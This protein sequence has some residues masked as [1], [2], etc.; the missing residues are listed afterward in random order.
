[1]REGR[2]EGGRGSEHYAIAARPK[3]LRDAR[4][5]HVFLTL[6]PPPRLVS[7]EAQN[8]AKAGNSSAQGRVKELEG[9]LARARELIKS[10]EASSAAELKRAKALATSI[11]ATMKKRGE[12]AEARQR[13][14]SARGDAMLAA[15]NLRP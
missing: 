8:I 13:E 15:V 6:R 11:A 14:V 5:S 2:R 4:S 12:E 9:D 1:M 10:K 7:R 3:K